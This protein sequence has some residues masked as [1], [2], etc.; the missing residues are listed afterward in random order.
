MDLSPRE[1]AERGLKLLRAGLLGPKRRPASRDPEAVEILFDTIRRQ[2]DG[3]A[4]RPGTTIQWDFTDADPWYLR[5]DNGATAVTQGRAPAPD[6]TLKV[7]FDD[8]AD[9]SA[10]RADPR[11][12]V[13]RR[14]LR[15][16]GRPW[17][18]LRLPKILG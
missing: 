2:A 4:A 17:V 11:V 13:L 14:R 7:A 3:N 5:C 6:V 15:V 10:G 8:F 12:L 9:V 1:R 18:V 16:R